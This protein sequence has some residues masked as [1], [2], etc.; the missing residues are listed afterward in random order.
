[1]TSCRSLALLIGILLIGNAQAEEPF[2]VGITTHLM[3]F[4][5]SPRPAL[6]LAKDAGF[7]ALKDDVFWSTAEPVPHQLRI[8]QQWRTYLEAATTLNFTKLAILGY[9][10]SFY[11]NAKPRSGEVRDGYLN[12]VDYVTRQLGNRVNLYE[13]W[14]EWDLEAPKSIKLANDYVALVRDTVP[15]IRK[16]TV[17]QNGTPAK[18][19]AG[20]VT[21]EGMDYGFADHLI[22]SGVINQV[23]GLSI[24]PYAH[25]A[26]NNGRSPEHWVNWVRD[27][28][29]HIRSR[30][31][32]AIPIYISEMAW[33]SHTGNCG[34]STAT[35]AAY[36]ARIFFFA[37]TI[38]NLKGMWWYDLVNDG[39][40]RTDQEHNFGLLNEN[41]SPK[42]AY[43]VMK[44]I[45][46]IVRD[47][48]YDPANS[49]QADDVYMLNFRKG[50]EHVVA[51]WAAGRQQEKQLTSAHP[52]AG[53][54][55]LIDTATPEKGRFHGDQS[56][57]CQGEVCSVN[58]QLTEFPKII[59][60]GRSQ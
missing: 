5:A 27:Y 38:P 26:A 49:V 1:M 18:V 53:P 36:M 19:L 24:H 14:N 16:N 51:V 13:I 45:A 55:Q 48:N 47:F 50:D 40:D 22:D 32:R 60:L 56:W 58:V 34:Y 15:L 57:V 25:C 31:K 39:P 2:I 11:Q 23:D 44:A 43:N 42:P 37:R 8:A 52:Q 33:P 12:Y 7:T 29:Q 54:L 35:Q 46:P 20:S 4:E 59:S 41:L 3:N 6:N 28:E 10:T 9:S 30:A 17:G 21:P